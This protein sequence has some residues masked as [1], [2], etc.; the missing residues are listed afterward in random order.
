MGA[1]RVTDPRWKPLVKQSVHITPSTL[2]HLKSHLPGLGPI[3]VTIRTLI[4]GRCGIRATPA[5]SLQSTTAED[6][7]Y[8]Q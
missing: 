2:P 3:R 4:E 7:L 5:G 6:R 1:K 8:L